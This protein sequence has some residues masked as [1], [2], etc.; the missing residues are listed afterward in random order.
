MNVSSNDVDLVESVGVLKVRE[1]ATE[2]REW[3]SWLIRRRER[4]LPQKD[5]SSKLQPRWEEPMEVVDI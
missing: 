4:N 2:P 1:K 3:T 5:R